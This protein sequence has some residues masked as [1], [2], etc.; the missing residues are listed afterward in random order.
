MRRP[1][2]QGGVPFSDKEKTGRQI[3]SFFNGAFFITDTFFMMACKQQL[4]L[5]CL[6]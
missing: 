4:E 2:F 6:E 1:V 3:V 5:R